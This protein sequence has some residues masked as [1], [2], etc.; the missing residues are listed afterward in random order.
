MLVVAVNIPLI[1]GLVTSLK[2]NADISQNPLRLPT[3]F[4]L[5]HYLRLNSNPQFDF[6]KY[7]TNSIALSTGAM[8]LTAFLGVPATY[9]IVVL[10]IGGSRLLALVTSLRVVPAIMMMLPFFIMFTKAGL[11]DSIWALIFANTILQI[12]LVVLIYAAGMRSV[13]DS[14]LDAARIDGAGELGVL[15]RI[16]LPI[17]RPSIASAALLTFVFA[18]SE[19]L[20][21]LVLTTDSAVPLTVGVSNFVTNTGTQWGDLS[22]TVIVSIIPTLL[23]AIFAQ[24]HLVGG[25]TAGAMSGV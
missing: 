2:T 10:R 21:G 5:D 18:W 6:W 3:H 23:V 4:T 1:I 19:Y 22:A 20:F 11:I 9:G 24:K 14:I 8:I 7:I 25:L 15:L 17:I 16:V 13:P 12:P